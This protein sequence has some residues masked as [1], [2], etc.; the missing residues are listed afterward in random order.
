MNVSSIV[1]VV[2]GLTMLV[3]AQVSTLVHAQDV[4]KVVFSKTV[5]VANGT[6]KCFIASGSGFNELPNSY[7]ISSQD[8]GGFGTVTV[9]GVSTTYVTGVGSVLAPSGDSVKIDKQSVAVIS[10][11]AFG[12]A[13]IGDAGDAGTACDSLVAFLSGSGGGYIYVGLAAAGIVALADGGDDSAEPEPEPE[14]QPEP[15]P[16]PEPE[17]PRPSPIAPLPASPSR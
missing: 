7:L 9:D 4:P 6:V 14:P 17:Q 10:D 8:S 15:E 1:K 11:A 3:G 12:A 2:L 5:E 13:P 16:E